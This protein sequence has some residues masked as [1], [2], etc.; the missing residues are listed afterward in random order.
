[1]R[2][3]GTVHRFAA[4]AIGEPGNRTFMLQLDTA[5]GRSTY[6]L[7]KNQLAVL[8]E[9]S[10]DMLDHIGFTGVGT[11]LEPPA[12]E[13]PD[14]FEFRVGSVQLSY[15]EGSG[16]VTLAIG[17]LD[18]DEDTVRYQ[19]TPAVL[20]AAVRHGLEVVAA[21][22]PACP[23]CGL[24]MDSEGHHCPKDNGDLRHHRP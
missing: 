21:G 5:T 9:Q 6:L 22:R 10:L 16:L 3:G 17:P 14:E 4:G 8:S 7:E 23:R 20:D 13:E 12:V 18:D 15:E 24:A 2:D 1:M 19:M 11:A